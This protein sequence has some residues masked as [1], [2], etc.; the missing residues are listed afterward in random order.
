MC[1]IKVGEIAIKNSKCGYISM[2]RTTPPCLKPGFISSCHWLTLPRHLYNRNPC[3][4]AH[5]YS[6]IGS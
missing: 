4:S 1:T 2:K 5:L 6:V 3:P